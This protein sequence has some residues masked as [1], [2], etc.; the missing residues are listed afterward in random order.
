MD[1]KLAINL[2]EGTITAEGSEEFVRFIYA[3]FKESVSKQAVQISQPL[4]LEAG[5]SGKNEDT[6]VEGK[7]AT[8]KTQSKGRSSSSGG[9]EK[10]KGGEYKPTFVSTLNLK[11]LEQFYDAFDPK[12]HSDKILIFAIFL[13]DNLDMATCTANDIY[14]CYF[15]LKS[16]TKIPTA[17][18][19]A[20]KDT[21]AR[22]H[23]I[24]YE[25]FDSISV[26]ITGENHFSSIMA[27]KAK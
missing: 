18:L 23:F 9:R 27:D 17:F 19:Q 7:V 8:N 6:S 2:R 20:F 3:D 25:S 26:S 24:D 21:K 15:T 13:R 16:K 12:N 1:T 5:K 10:S 22:T 4:L 11:G 14:T